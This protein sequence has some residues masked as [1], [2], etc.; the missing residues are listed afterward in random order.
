MRFAIE[1]RAGQPRGTHSE[2]IEVGDDTIIGSSSWL[3]ADGRRR[4][5]F[6]VLTVR[7]GKIVD[8]QG[9]TSLRQAKRFARAC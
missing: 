1:K 8:M 5:R 9:F 2:L 4:E 3:D 6:Q 7:N